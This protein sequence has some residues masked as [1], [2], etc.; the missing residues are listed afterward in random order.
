MN[1]KLPWPILYIGVFAV[2]LL[3]NLTLH[4]TQL[5]VL[6]N[7]VHGVSPSS[8]LGIND[9]GEA[10]G[11]RYVG[12]ATPFVYS[13]G[14]LTGI[15]LPFAGTDS[16]A[17]GI[18][19]SGQVVGYFNKSYDVYNYHSFVYSNSTVTDIGNLGGGYCKAYGINNSGL[20]VGFSYT[21]A[22]T[23]SGPVH[24]FVYSTTTGA[25]TDIGTLGGQ[26]SQAKGINNA[27]QITGQAVTASGVAHAFVYSTD[28]GTM[29]DLGTLGGNGSFGNSI[30]N[31]GEVVG[32]SSLSNS[33]VHA[34][35]YSN[36]TMNDIGTLGGASSSYALSINDSGLVVGYSNSRAFLYSASS[37]M[38]DLST[39]CASLLVS[40]TGS[41]PGFMSLN[42]ASAINNFG[43]IVGTG[44]YWNGDG[45]ISD[46]AFLLTGIPEPST[47]AM[48]DVGLVLMG[49]A[50]HRRSRKIS[51]A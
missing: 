3:S 6:D 43:D 44:Q 11:Y 28:N 16:Q 45:S 51:V 1:N 22:N 48:L 17:C 42:Q 10:V 40:G 26:N 8:G 50:L 13:S 47:W 31:S 35:V 39:L 34:F 41:E 32:F 15:G 24:A 36:N 19:N 21:T 38:Q 25:M 14:T 12:G 30:N 5:S 23:I 20:V 18:N 9:L 27:G 49:V 33:S 4:A 46:K 37:G 2:C 29:T 7:G